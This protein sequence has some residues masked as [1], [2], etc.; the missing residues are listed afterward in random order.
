MPQR[1]NPLLTGYIYHLYNRGV[2]REKIFYSDRNYLFF[3]N[4]MCKYLP[5]HSECFAFCLMPNH[6]HLLIKIIDEEFVSKALQPLMVSYS[7]AI[8]SELG[9]IGPLFQGR[10]QAN[11]I[12][13][14]IQFLDCLKY[15]HL[16]PVQARFVS[17]P[18]EWAYSS[19]RQYL[20][21]RS[22]T[23]LI[24]SFALEYFG[25]LQEFRDFN[26]FGCADFT[27]KFSDD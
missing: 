15:I 22:L 14:K 19:Y 24:T 12:E 17:H 8:N 18:T 13:D 9:R 26:E 6:F 5:R 7:K 3:I 25:N 20:S 27:S 23:F 1:L 2:N 10:F 21:A 16:N 11:L 4:Q